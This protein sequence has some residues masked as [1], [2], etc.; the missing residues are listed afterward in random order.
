[1]QAELTALAQ[2]LYMFRYCL[3]K[4]LRR[5]VVEFMRSRTL[6]AV[7]ADEDIA[8]GAQL[9]G[10]LATQRAFNGPPYTAPSILNPMHVSSHL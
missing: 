2:G 9:V 7:T 6:L 10:V 5:L 3:S 8:K 1:M 4:H